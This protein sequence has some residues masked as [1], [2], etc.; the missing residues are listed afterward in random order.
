[1]WNSLL[2]MCQCSAATHKQLQMFQ[3]GHWTQPEMWPH[4]DWA[5]KAQDQA[6]Q[7]QNSAKWWN[8]L[9]HLYRVIGPRC[10]CNWIKIEPK[11]LNI[12]HLNIKKVQEDKTTHLGHAHIAQPPINP[13]QCW[14]GVIVIGLICWCSCIKIEPRIISQMWEDGNTYLG[15]INTIQSTRSP[16]KRIKRLSELTVK[17]RMQGECWHCDGEYRWELH[18]LQSMQIASMMWLPNWAKSITNLHINKSQI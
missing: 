16:K 11:R 3:Y 12:K 2:W 1:M 4:Q 6:S 10:W 8:N 15:H 17:C 13:S 5:W 18:A 14:Y 9:E 7:W